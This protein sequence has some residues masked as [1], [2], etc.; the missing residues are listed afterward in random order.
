MTDEELTAIEADLIYFIAIDAQN[1]GPLSLTNEWAAEEAPK[2]IAEVRRLKAELSLAKDT[3]ELS[4]DRAERYLL[5]LKQLRLELD[6][7]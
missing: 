5:Q 7:R 3:G 2:L 6:E 4:Y 1:S